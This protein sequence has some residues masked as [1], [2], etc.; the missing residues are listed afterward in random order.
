MERGIYVDAHRSKK[1]STRFKGERTF[2]ETTHTTSTAK[3]GD[4]LTVEVTRLRNKLIVPGT[5]ALAFDMD[6]VLDPSEPGAAVN[7][8]P[9]N[10]LAANIVSQIV[11]KIGS[12][13]VHTLQNAHLYNT[14]KDLWLTEKQR[15]NAVFK[16]IQ[17]EEL[18]KM[19]T[20]LKTKFVNT[21]A[22]NL[23]LKNIFGKRYIMPLDF[24]L[25]NDHMALPTGAIEQTIVFELT[26]NKKEYVLKYSKETAD[27]TLKN[28]CVQYETVSE[29]SL[30]DSIKGQIGCYFLFDDVHHY[31]RKKILKKAELVNEIINVDR[32]SLKGILLLFQDAFTGG[33]RDSE[34]FPNPEIENVKIT[35]GSPNQIYSE[36]VKQLHHWDEICKHFVSEDLKKT[37]DLYMDIVKYYCDNKYALWIDFR[38]PED[39]T[40]HGAGNGYKLNEFSML[41]ITKKNKGEGEYTMH[42]FVV[43]DARI[44][45]EKNKFG[46]IER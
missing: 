4:I 23:I 21:K 33:E 18:R 37:H 12:E 11:V 1:I 26:I 6:I 41:D 27:F 38:T 3:P 32:K 20:D 2:Y 19:R 34:H 22:S 25:I 14:F 42:I 35:I 29:S 44:K 36:R 45:I 30:T 16:G 15:T 9:V 43:A 7:T 8:Y 24:D 46:N 28:I 40:L 17:D 13:V 10:N 5:F 31:I 39:N